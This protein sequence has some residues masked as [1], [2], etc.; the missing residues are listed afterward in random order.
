MRKPAEQSAEHHYL[1]EHQSRLPASNKRPSTS[2]STSPHSR[3][4]DRAGGDD[5]SGN[6]APRPKLPFYIRYRDLRAAGIVDSWQQ[7]YNLI[8]D[9]GF[10]PGVLI[11]A[12]VRARDIAE[13][14]QWL[15]N[16]STERKAVPPRRNP[17]A[18]CRNQARQ[19]GNPS[20]PPAPAPQ[21]QSAP[22]LLRATA[23]QPSRR[24]TEAAVS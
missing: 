24:Q 13:V 18:A 6:D 2:T 12:N 23:A 5:G 21:N 3:Q 20:R 4:G 17:A 11:S 16:R 9:Y 14:K 19:D 15:A 8:D 22:A 7:L 10:P 1:G